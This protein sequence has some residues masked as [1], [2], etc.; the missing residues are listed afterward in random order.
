MVIRFRPS[1]IRLSYVA[2]CGLP[3]SLDLPPTEPPLTS[4]EKLA[5]VPPQRGFK[6]QGPASWEADSHRWW[7][8]DR[9]RLRGRPFSGG[10]TKSSAPQ[11]NRPPPWPD[12]SSER[13]DR[14]PCGG[15][16]GQTAPQFLAPCSTEAA[17]STWSACCVVA[18]VELPIAGCALKPSQF[19]DR[20]ALV[21][22]AGRGSGVMDVGGSRM[23]CFLLLQQ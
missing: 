6:R 5:G 8:S 11:R 10:S 17:I 18:T 1:H 20:I 3:P 23:L 7:S 15:A 12:R 9:I 2:P 14:P 13:P 4:G 19:P 16:P 22:W 21:R